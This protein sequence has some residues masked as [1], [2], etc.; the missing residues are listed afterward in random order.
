M[1]KSFGQSIPKSLQL[2]K[3]AGEVIPGGIYG[4]TSPAGGLPGIFPYYAERAQGGRYWDVDGREMLDFM[5]GYGTNIL[6]YGDPEVETAARR[7]RERGN[8]FNHPAEVSVELAET[9]VEK[10]DFANWVVFGK[11]G[12]DMTTW[13]V[14]VCREYT[15]K[16]KVLMVEGAYHGVDSW[17]TPGKGGLIEE[18]RRQVHHF[19]W[20]RA[21]QLER[22]LKEHRGQVA[23]LILTPFHHPSFY[24]SQMPE[25]GFFEK[26]QRLCRKEGVLIVLDDIR[27]GFRLAMGGS[28]RRFG[29]EPDLACYCKAIANGYPL[30]VTAGRHFLKASASRVF[31]TGSYWNN[32]VAMA[33][34]L[35]CIRAI[36]ARSVPKH[37]E[38]LGSGLMAGLESR[39]GHYGL[40]VYT[41]GPPAMPFLSFRGD[42]DFFLIQEFCSLCIEQGVFFHPHHN[43]FLCASHTEADID[44]ALTVAD[45]AFASISRKGAHG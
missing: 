43:W 33:A 22:L 10:I 4:H 7:Q 16:P 26:V 18:D 41:S 11:N 30:S 8:T 36:E 24:P 17:C 37:L 15:G 13:A 40:P 9:F 39:G 25:P 42:A 2:L 29:L 1:N 6:G 35:A 12:S 44:Q 23:C 19:S 45:S 21:D 20:N 27:A 32:A 5:C 38:K 34:S 28:H 3:R 31:L 14:Q